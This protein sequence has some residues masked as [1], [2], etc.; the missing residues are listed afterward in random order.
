[1]TQ[2]DDPLCDPVTMPA[3]LVLTRCPGILRRLLSFLRNVPCVRHT[4]LD[5]LDFGVVGEVGAVHVEKDA[6]HNLVAHVLLQVLL[7]GLLHVHALLSPLQ[8]E[9]DLSF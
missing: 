1:M 6:A 5:P 4:P 8:R 7:C 2:F 3:V 9:L